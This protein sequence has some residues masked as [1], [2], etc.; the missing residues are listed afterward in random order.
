MK[1]NIF[2][3]FVILII[4]IFAISGCSSGKEVNKTKD[5]SN[6]LTIYTTIYP[7]QYFTERIGGNYVITKNIV[8]QGADAHSTDI[9]LKTMQM[10]SESDAFIYTGTGLEGYADAVTAA[11]KKKDVLIVNAS[12][13]IKFIDSS[14]VESSRAEEEHKDHENETDIDPHI[15]LDPIRSITVAENIKKSLIKLEPNNKKTFEEN[16]ESLKKELVNLDSNFKDLIKQSKRNTFLVSHSA[17]GYWEEAYG[18]K[19]IGISGLSPTNEPSQKQLKNIIDLALKNELKY[20]FFEPNV[21]NKI[22]EVVKNETGTK[23]LILQNLESITSENKKNNEDY[24]DVMRNNIEAL[25]TA[26]N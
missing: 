15:W 26:L 4:T 21:S 16:F 12:K 13:N 5:G 1:K 19:Q 17:Y 3:Y 24:F 14:E 10:V 7:L 20:I 2:F 23:P 6:K 25:R 8:P 22:A 9:R 18:L 11:L